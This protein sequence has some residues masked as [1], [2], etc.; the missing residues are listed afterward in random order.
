MMYPFL[1]KRENQTREKKRT[2]QNGRH[3]GWPKVYALDAFV[4]YS[5]EL[6]ALNTDPP[7]P[8]PPSQAKNFQNFEVVP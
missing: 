6:F 4:A 3:L 1:N 7:P 2:V 5:R 8:P